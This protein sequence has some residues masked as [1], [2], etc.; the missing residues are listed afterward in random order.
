MVPFADHIWSCALCTIHCLFCSRRHCVDFGGKLAL[1]YDLTSPKVNSSLVIFFFPNFLGYDIIDHIICYIWYIGSISIWVLLAPQKLHPSPGVQL[2]TQVKDVYYG[3]NVCIS[4]KFICWSL[5]WSG[6]FGEEAIGSRRQN[7]HRVV[8]HQCPYEKRKRAIPCHLHHARIQGKGGY[9]Q[10][11][12]WALIWHA[13][14]QFTEHGSPSP[15]HC[16]K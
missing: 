13:F 9:L 16:E 14:C 1:Q 8:S 10:A 2:T 15:Q 4:P 11:R 7:P 6:G 12:K 5:M 3:L